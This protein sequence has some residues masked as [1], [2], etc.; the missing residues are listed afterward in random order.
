MALLK[1]ADRYSPQCLESSC[2]KAFSYITSPNL[3]IVQSILKS[4]QGELL[5]ED[6]LARP[7]ESKTHMFARGAG[8]YKG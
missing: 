5:A 4:S 8:Y 2:R 1:L 6:A 3:K 7:E